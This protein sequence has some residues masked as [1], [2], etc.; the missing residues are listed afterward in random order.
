MHGPNPLVEGKQLAFE[1]QIRDMGGAGFEQPQ[2]GGVGAAG[3]PGVVER[4]YQ[5]LQALSR[6]F[7]GGDTKTTGGNNPAV[8]EVG[9]CGWVA[10]WVRWWVK[11]SIQ[12]ASQPT[13]TRCVVR[14]VSSF[15]FYMNAQVGYGD[16]ASELEQ[17]LKASMERAATVRDDDP[18]SFHSIP[19]AP[20][21]TKQSQLPPPR[22]T[23]QAMASTTKKPVVLEQDPP[24]VHAPEL[25]HPEAVVSMAEIRQQKQQQQGG[26][27]SSTSNNLGVKAAVRAA[28]N[29]LNDMAEDA[30]EGIGMVGKPGLGGGG[31]GGGGGKKGETL[32]ARDYMFYWTG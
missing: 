24:H 29:N 14:S 31:S 30:R 6:M 28:V 26:S 12:E 27:S 25:L 32:T 23:K 7:L 2:P 20:P 13:T 10:G 21:K 22:P 8:G 18:S 5:G 11:Q 1:A 3:G 15:L 19:I 17:D 9:V 16:P 4:A